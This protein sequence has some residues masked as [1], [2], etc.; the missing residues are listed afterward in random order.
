MNGYKIRC[1][2][3]TQ[4]ASVFQSYVD[5]RIHYKTDG[6][7]SMCRALDIHPVFW[8]RYNHGWCVFLTDAK[9]EELL[10]D[11]VDSYRQN[12]VRIYAYIESLGETFDGPLYRKIQNSLDLIRL[13]QPE[14]IIP[15]GITSI[16]DLSYFDLSK[17]DSPTPTLTTDNIDQRVRAYN[18][19][20]RRTN[21]PRAAISAYVQ[22]NKWLEENARNVGN[23][24]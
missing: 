2:T 23:L 17:I 16:P 6:H 8:Q 10:P 19:T 7:V 12:Y 20:Y 1:S 21:N 3:D 22:G 18:T 11:I 14:L 24:R 9:A 4:T 15:L 13:H 5:C